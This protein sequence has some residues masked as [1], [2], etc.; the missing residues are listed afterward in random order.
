MFYSYM[1]DLM[2]SKV[3]AYILYYSNSV[4]MEKERHAAM[5]DKELAKLDVCRKAISASQAN[6]VAFNEKYKMGNRNKKICNT[7]NNK[8]LFIS[9]SVRSSSQAFRYNSY[10]AVSFVWNKK[11]LK[12]LHIFNDNVYVSFLF[13]PFKNN[14]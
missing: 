7:N 11:K 6:I 9:H 3:H 1:L 4:Y 14:L 8:H 12:Y 5:C 10:R 13:A 2:N